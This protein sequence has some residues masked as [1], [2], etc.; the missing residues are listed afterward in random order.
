MRSPPHLLSAPSKDTSDNFNVTQNAMHIFL[1]G[2]V[3][4]IYT[5][6]ERNGT[7]NMA[8]TVMPLR[9]VKVNTI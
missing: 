9:V 8:V 5:H 6:L 2:S 3:L 1:Y 4:N 7:V